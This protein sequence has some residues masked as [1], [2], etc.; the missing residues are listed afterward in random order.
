M[1]NSNFN[2]SMKDHFAFLA[3]IRTKAFGHGNHVKPEHV[4]VLLGLLVI[5]R[6]IGTHMIDDFGGLSKARFV[7]TR[8]LALE[9]HVTMTGFQMSFGIRDISIA[10][11]TSEFAF[12]GPVMPLGLEMILSAITTIIPIK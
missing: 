3:S 5:T 10:K 4:N 9:G 11:V 2:I 1:D 12:D 6:M 8:Q 7:A